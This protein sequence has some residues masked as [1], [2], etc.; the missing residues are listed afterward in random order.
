MA[1]Q[2]PPATNPTGS[3]AR[4]APGDSAAAAPGTEDA[5]FIAFAKENIGLLASVASVPLLSSASG[6]L[7][8]PLQMDHLT[9]L[10]SLLCVIV[11]AACFTLRGILGSAPLSRS[12]VVRALPGLASLGLA[13]AAIYLVASFSTLQK[14]YEPIG[15][16]AAATAT[17]ARTAT[18]PGGP[19]VTGGAGATGPASSVGTSGSA[20]TGGAVGTGGV[21]GTGG[22]TGASGVAG[23]GS[24]AVPAAP[25]GTTK[26]AKTDDPTQPK[27]QSTDTTSGTERGTEEIRTRVVLFLSIFPTMTLALGLI[28]VTNFTQQT[29]HDIQTL[30]EQKLQDQAKPLFE[31]L[32][33]IAQFYEIGR[34]PGNER[35]LKIGEELI[36]NRNVFLRQ[37]SLGVIEVGGAEA[38][39]M[40]QTLVHTFRASF[41]AVSCCDLDFWANIGTDDM[42]RSYFR[43]N[44]EAVKKSDKV[45]RLLIFSDTE[46]SR[47]QDVVS[48]LEY[49]QRYGI[50]W[51]VVPYMDLDPS[52]REEDDEVA[53]DFGLFDESQVAI[54]FRDYQSGSRKLRAVFP[55]QA[56]QDFIARQRGR[57][58]D[59]ATQCWLVTGAFASRLESLY[60]SD[61][62]TFKTGVIKNA[63]VT[64]REL[65]MTERV[66]V[67]Q[68]LDPVKTSLVDCFLFGK[69]ESDITGLAKR[70][71]TLRAASKDFAGPK[72]AS[73]ANLQGG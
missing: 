45:T 50:A 58:R 39:K 55:G 9:V 8:P 5:R 16:S 53:L 18:G 72:A 66:E 62:A 2:P 57:Y 32:R 40:Q 70:M 6:A 1:P 10:S 67:L 52:T 69:A 42:S 27:Q 4:P 64:A 68:S 24:T 23:V 51:A 19:G 65:G 61:L 20:G 71:H 3:A 33:L 34:L 25:G 12:M 46:L 30:I 63:L 17:A 37:L 28:L 21:T 15:A 48:V 54:Y 43:L 14:M 31:R 22:A 56:R 13:A 29:A 73:A 44:L 7:K 41:D 60:Q 36:E 59:L 47:T 35:F 11:F 49:H 26:S 38:I